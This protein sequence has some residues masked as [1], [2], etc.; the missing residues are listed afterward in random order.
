MSTFVLKSVI[1][2]GIVGSVFG[3]A[4]LVITPNAAFADK[5]DDLVVKG[6]SRIT[7]GAASQ[8]RVDDISEQTDK[9]IAEYHKELKSAA[10]LKSYNDQLRRTTGAQ[11]EAMAKLEQS[12]EDASLIERQIIPLMQRMIEGLDQFIVA[13]MPFKLDERKARIERIRSYLTN[14]NITAAERFRQVLAAYSTETAYG[15]S[16]DVYT[17]ELALPSGNLTVNVLQVGRTG[18]YYQTLDGTNS[19]YWDKSAGNWVELDA[20]HN[21]GIT[22][23]IRI[24]QG[25]ESKDLMRLPIAAPEAI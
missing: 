5:V 14:A 13:D 21:E 2:K 7:S 19:G 1:K 4:L 11:K 6:K 16:I 15:Q 22:S 10:T 24:T 8:K 3:V 9:V 12:I 25:K 20:S 23:A 18:L 17:E